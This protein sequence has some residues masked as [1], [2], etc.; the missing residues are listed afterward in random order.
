MGYKYILAFLKRS[1][2]YLFMRTTLSEVKTKAQT[3]GQEVLL[4][5]EILNQ[6]VASLFDREAG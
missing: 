6:L 5:V 2:M 1:L 3:L 4:S